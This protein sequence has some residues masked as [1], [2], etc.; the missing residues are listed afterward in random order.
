MAFVSKKEL[1]LS[2]VML[3]KKRIQTSCY[4]YFFCI[5]IKYV[6]LLFEKTSH[7]EKVQWGTT[8]KK[9]PCWNR[10]PMTTKFCSSEPHKMDVS[11]NI[12]LLRLFFWSYFDFKF[13]QLKEMRTL[14]RKKV[15]KKVRRRKEFQHLV[16]ISEF[17]NLCCLYSQ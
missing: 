10:G 15:H 1:D 14:T 9:N 11:G 8:T 6:W 2:K 7:T 3:K 5:S 4:L 17:G 16:G 13:S 12:L